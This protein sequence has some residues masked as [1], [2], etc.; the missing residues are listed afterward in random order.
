MDNHSGCSVP[1]R[2]WL[3]TRLLRIDATGSADSFTVRLLETSRDGVSEGSRF[4]ALSHMWG[5][6]T[7]SP[8]LRALTSNLDELKRE[9][10]FDKLPRTFADAAK[11]CI[12]LGVEF[13]WIDSLCIV[14]DSPEDW[15]C[16]A[17]VMHLVYR[18]AV[19]T[20]VA[21]S[22]TSSHDGFLHRDLGRI[23]AVKMAYPCPSYD[24]VG[25]EAN[26][27]NHMVIFQHEQ[28]NQ[29][30]Y[31]L[32]AIN[33]SRWNTRGW[34]MQERS[35]STRTLHFC[36][37]KI[38][39][40]CRDGLRSEENEAPH[41]ADLSS[42]IMWPRSPSISHS[43]L[44]EHWELFLI[45]YCMRRLTKET[46]KLPA[47]QSI[48][49]EM[50]GVTKHRYIPFAGMWRERLD[51]ELLWWVASAD[52]SRPAQARAP[53]W[54]WASVNGEIL[55]VSQVMRSTPSR[56]QSSPLMMSLGRQS[57]EILS[58]D[59]A[60]GVGSPSPLGRL[61][62]RSLARAISKLERLS[63]PGRWRRFFP[64][65]LVVA[66]LADLDGGTRTVIAH[67]KLDMEGAQSVPGRHR[68]LLY[69]H[70]DSSTRATGLILEAVEQETSQPSV[71][72]MQGW[73][74]RRLGV[75]TLFADRSGSPIAPDVFGPDDELRDAILI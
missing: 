6:A 15:R 70:V 10:R 36:R 67:G 73:L 51:Q 5:D 23:P 17:G 57:L 47:I 56:S 45:E 52:S 39:F 11:V 42:S 18:Y 14:Q 28:E 48:A 63:N 44:Y 62:V 31:R 1:P 64:Y 43:A 8:P 71:G 25:V 59:E 34:T 26:T 38:F 55:F 13:L 65:D 22:A 46:D 21:T 72:M 50:A 24:G 40:E 35:L 12:K 20:V 60:H 54:S 41:E 66:P 2:P 16:E 49:S 30:A 58:L 53:S 3:P 61:Q 37:N 74:W 9:V 33:Q 69:L 4:V 7:V 68:A 27:D 32:H 75:A 29:G 19:V